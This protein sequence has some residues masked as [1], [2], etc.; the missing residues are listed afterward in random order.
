MSRRQSITTA[1]K[2][3]LESIAISV[4]ARAGS[5]PLRWK[6]HDR[7]ARERLRA[8]DFFASDSL[9]STG[10]MKRYPRRGRVSTKRGLSEESPR[11]SRTRFTAA[12]RPC[13]KSPK[14]S[15]GQSFCF[16]SSRVT[17]SPGWRQ[18]GFED[19]EGLAGQA[20]ADALLAQFCGA[21]VCLENAE[22]DDVRGWGWRLGLGW[23]G[24]AHLKSSTS[25]R[26]L[27]VSS[28]CE[29][30]SHVSSGESDRPPHQMG[31]RSNKI[32]CVTRCVE[33]S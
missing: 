5:G 3:R 31:C 6:R 24:G 30:A 15:E 11:A 1:G 13:S 10:A 18:Q 33:R 23:R 29:Y 21:Q 2:L 26:W 7:Q 27:L 19:L 22:A 32:F 17:S 4:R 16:S 28:I 8:V 25:I 12:L 9:A 14:E 20:D